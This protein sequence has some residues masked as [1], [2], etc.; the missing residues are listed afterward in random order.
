ML[1]IWRSGPSPLQDRTGSFFPSLEGT[2]FV[3]LLAIGFPSILKR[4]FVALRFVEQAAYRDERAVPLEVTPAPD[5][6]TRVFM[7]FRDV[8]KED[9][10]G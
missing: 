7:L 3:G 1:A 6:V 2:F 5:V 4:E 10:G 9:L 8:G